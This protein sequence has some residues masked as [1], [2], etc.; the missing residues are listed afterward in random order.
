MYSE[1]M[2]Y[3]VPFTPVQLPN[4]GNLLSKPS[5]HSCSGLAALPNSSCHCW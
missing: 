3:T 1:L 2:L 4:F 5:P